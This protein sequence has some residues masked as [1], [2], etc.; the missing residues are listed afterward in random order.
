M[1]KSHAWPPQ[2]HLRTRDT[3][4]HKYELLLA[5]LWTMRTS[6]ENCNKLAT[7]L[8]EFNSVLLCPACFDKEIERIS[9]AI[10]EP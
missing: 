10:V 3:T 2:A 9:A 7:S 1:S 6:C 8:I 5:Y 4:I